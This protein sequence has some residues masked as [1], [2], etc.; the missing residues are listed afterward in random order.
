V[1][2]ALSGWLLALQPAQ[3]DDRAT[4]EVERQFTDPASG[5]DVIVSLTPSAV[6]LNGLRVEVEAPQD[7]I[8]NLVVVFIPPAGSEAPGIEQPIPLNGAGTAVLDREVG[9]P[10]DVPGTWTMQL[11][12]STETGSVTDARTPFPVSGDADGEIEPDTGT[13]EQDEPE[14]TDGSDDTTPADTPTVITVEVDIDGD[15]DGD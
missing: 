14:D 11:S 8:T 1:V 13:G 12:G 9:L 2:L 3:I 7:G 10:F 5:L 15:I 4:Y 6:G